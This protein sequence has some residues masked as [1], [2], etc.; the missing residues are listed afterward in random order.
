MADRKVKDRSLREELDARKH[1]DSEKADDASEKT[2]SIEPPPCE[3]LN[4]TISPDETPHTILSFKPGDPTNPRNWSNTKKVFVVVSGILLVTNSTLGSSIPS[5][6][7]DETSK[8][9]NVTSE[10]QLVLPASMYLLG[11]VLGPLAFSP[12]SETY[13]RQIVMRS[14]FAIYTAF[15]LGCALAPSWAGLVVMRLLTGIGASTPLSVIGG[16]YADIYATPKA[17][18]RAISVF[19]CS[20]CFGPLLGPVMSGFIA[21]VSWRWAYWLQLIIAGATWPLLL[22]MP[23]TF[24]PTIL[25]KQAKKMRKESGRDDVYAPTELEHRDMREIFV[26][27]LTRPIRLFLFEAVVLCSCLYLS[28]IYAIFYMFLQ[29]YPII[30]KGIYGFNSGEEGLAF[31]PIGIGSIIACLIYLYW[32]H[33]LDQQRA[34]DPAPAWSQKVEYARVPLACL[35]APLL[36]ASMFWLGWAARPDIHWSVPMV[37]AIPFGI[38]YLLVFIALINYIVDAYEV[39]SASAM[40]A[41]S[42]SRSLFGAVLPFATAPMFTKLGVAWACS[43]LGFLS[44]LMGIIPFLFLKYGDTIRANSKFGQELKK[45]KEDAEKKEREDEERMIDV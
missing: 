23:E 29:S 44:M 4:S 17:R 19:M 6:A 15:T 3:C 31:L 25:A 34:R 7:S 2:M 13:G 14:T 45:Q 21:P 12:L 10:T 11:Y 42:C 8:Y 37:S 9:F 27:V 28:L 33:W 22:T 40:A 1:A 24:A 36:P 16:I 18:G 41:A 5:G 35:G 43:L 38:A 32:D 20:T 30:Y 39:Y 26:V